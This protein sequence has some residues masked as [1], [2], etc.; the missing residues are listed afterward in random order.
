MRRLAEVND[1]EK[2]Q[3][4]FYLFVFGGVTGGIPRRGGSGKAGGFEAWGRLPPQYVIAMIHQHSSIKSSRQ[5]RP[6]KSEGLH[7]IISGL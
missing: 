7:K 6:G 1:L 3:G 4:G 5:I 2:P